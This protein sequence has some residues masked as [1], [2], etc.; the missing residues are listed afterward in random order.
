ME[1]AP[2]RE[3]RESETPS[4]WSPPTGSDPK[5]PMTAILGRPVVMR[6]GEGGA[7]R[8]AKEV[9]KDDDQDN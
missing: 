9:Q 1:W 2:A 8:T 3:E 4:S 5:L 6:I 7:E